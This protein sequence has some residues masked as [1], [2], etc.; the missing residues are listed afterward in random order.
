VRAYS[1]LVGDPA[2]PRRK[3]RISRSEERRTLI[4]I[5]VIACVPVFGSV[6]AIT[7][8]TLPDLSELSPLQ[9]QTPEYAVLGWSSL[10]RG[11]SSTLNARPTIF[12]GASIQAL[13]YMMDGA[14]PIRAGQ[15][16][17]SFVL[18]PDAGQLLHPAHRFGDQMIAVQLRDGDTIKFSPRALVWVWGTLQ[19]SPGDPVGNEPLYA[20]RDARAIP[21]LRADIDKYFRPE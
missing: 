9:A 1:Y 6:W 12:P 7:A 16:T 19:S 15:P 14:R 10:L 2:A 13:G 17:N 21:A 5:I 18:L 4:V 11:H 20:L 8:T 3:L